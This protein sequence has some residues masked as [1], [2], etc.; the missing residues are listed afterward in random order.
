MIGSLDVSL[1]GLGCNNFGWRIDQEQTT[2]V[3]DAA[4]DAGINFF[5]TADTYGGTLSEQFLGKALGQ[6][7]DQVVL[8]TKFGNQVGDDPAS[9]GASA[10]WI[11][12]EVEASL[13]R[14]G[15]DRIDLYQLHRPDPKVPIAETLGALDELVRAGKVIEIGCSNFT[16]AMIEEAEEAS[17][18]NGWGHFASVQNNYSALDRRAERDVLPACGRLGLGFLPYFPLASGMLTGKYRR[19][20]VPPEGT[21]LGSAGEGAASAMTDVNF[22]I[23]ERLEVFGAER[24]RSVAEVAMAFL[25][26]RSVVSSVIAGATR[27]E[28]VHA[29]AAGVSWRLSPEEI[30]ELDRLAVR[31]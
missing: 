16:T 1:A 25:A 10:A 23:V 17:N 13:G 21:R 24:G 18:A 5:D 3:V 29:N 9:S 28:Q 27:P 11:A 2:Q 22:D 7:R 12:K 8:A 30:A 19:G 15:T 26:S 20:Q 6:R 4:L 31:N 14:L